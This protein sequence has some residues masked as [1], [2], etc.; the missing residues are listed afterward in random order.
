M[1]KDPTLVPP[2]RP[3]PWTSLMRREFVA[4]CFVLAIALGA[5][6]WHQNSAVVVLRTHTESLDNVVDAMNARIAG[7]EKEQQQQAIQLASVAQST[8][9]LAAQVTQI[10]VELNRLARTQAVLE[11]R[12]RK[13][14]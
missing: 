7:T 8:T 5:H 6:I 1:M 11:E 9:S 3:N 2:E 4:L 10:S 14:E 12:T 13:D